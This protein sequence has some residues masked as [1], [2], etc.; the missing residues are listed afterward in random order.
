MTTPNDFEL[1]K[2]EDQLNVRLTGSLKESRPVVLDLF[3]DGC[4]L[5]TPLKARQAIAREWGGD[6]TLLRIRVDDAPELAER[7]EIELVPT[8]GLLLSDEE[9][10][11]R[12]FTDPSYSDGGNVIRWLRR[13]LGTRAV[14]DKAGR[15]TSA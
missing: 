3:A 4:P 8:V 15:T 6:V 9:K 10:S 12:K 7:Y 2:T 11:M 1:C 5:C 13:Q 14:E